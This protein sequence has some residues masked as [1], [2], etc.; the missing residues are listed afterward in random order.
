[1]VLLEN[2]YIMECYQKGITEI[3]LIKLEGI[4]IGWDQLIQP[5][6]TCNLIVLVKDYIFFVSILR[7]C[8]YFIEN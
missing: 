1:M 3:T 7:V 4:F 5:L 2:L 6:F 8:I